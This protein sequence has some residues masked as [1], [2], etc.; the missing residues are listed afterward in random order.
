M[1]PVAQVLVESEQLAQLIAIVD[2][3]SGRDFVGDFLSFA[4]GRFAVYAI[5]GSF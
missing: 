2:I 1:S 3:L 5:D 4:K